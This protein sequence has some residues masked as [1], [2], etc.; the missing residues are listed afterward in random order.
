MKKCS[1]ITMAYNRNDHLNNLFKGLSESSEIPCEVIVVDIDNTVELY[2]DYNFNIRKIACEKTSDKIPLAEARNLGASAAESEL[3]IFLDVD[4]IPSRDF[5]ANMILYLDCCPGLIM[6]RP[7]YLKHKVKPGFDE[8]YLHAHSMDHPDRMK[9]S[10]NIEQCSSYELFW[11]LCFGIPKNKFEVIHGF[12]KAYSGYGGEDTDFA[13]EAR[14]HGVSFYLS[15]AVAYHQQHPVYTPPINHLHDIVEN[16]NTF[17]H[18]W[19][20]WPMGAWLQAFVDFNLIDWSE[21]QTDDIPEPRQPAP[22]LLT[23]CLRP[24]APFA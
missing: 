5:V 22:A 21:N 1:L 9:P 7:R 23:Q 19:G 8:D 17:H 14:R 2:S 4:C 10:A 20:V 6:G 16:S 3:L 12:D 13:F 18:K 15:D 24:D 11:S